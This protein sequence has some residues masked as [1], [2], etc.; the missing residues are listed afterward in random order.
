MSGD[1]VSHYFAPVVS[2]NEDLRLMMIFSFCFW[3]VCQS[4]KGQSM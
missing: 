2:L 1:L 4:P 3:D